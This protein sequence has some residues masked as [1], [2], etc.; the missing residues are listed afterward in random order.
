MNID[1]TLELNYQRIKSRIQRWLGQGHAWLTE[2]VD[3][4][5]INISKYNPLSAASYIEL[6]KALDHP[7]KGLINIQNT[8]DNGCLR[9]HLKAGDRHSLRIRNVEREFAE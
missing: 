5:F 3:S 9:W 8:V 4:Q 7:R 2:S 1:K 6:P